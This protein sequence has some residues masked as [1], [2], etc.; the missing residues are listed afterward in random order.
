[1]SAFRKVRAAYI[2]DDPSGSARYMPAVMDLAR[3]RCRP[4]QV[5]NIEV[6]HD[7]RCPK[8]RGGECRCRPLVRVMDGPPPRGGN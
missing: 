3:E 8:L 1:M 6:R 5:T 7:D 4:G 2:T